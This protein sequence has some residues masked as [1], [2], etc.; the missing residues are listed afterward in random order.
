[1]SRAGQVTILDA[2]SLNERDLIDC[3]VGSV[4]LVEDNYLYTSDILGK[5]T[6]V[7]RYE[8]K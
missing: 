2:A 7:Y 1:M 5:V 3:T 4:V 6:R 8:R